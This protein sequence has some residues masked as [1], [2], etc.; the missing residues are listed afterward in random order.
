M[1]RTL[2]ELSATVYI[3]LALLEYVA[4]LESVVR[5]TYYRR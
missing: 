5:M 3:Y 1:S 4:G 2:L